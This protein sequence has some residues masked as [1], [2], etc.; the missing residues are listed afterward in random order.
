MRRLILILAISA[1]SLWA[2]TTIEAFGELPAATRDQ[3]GDTVGGIGSGLVFDAKNDQFFCISDRGPGDG[4]LPY[5]PRIAVLKIPQD[6]NTLRPEVLRTIILKDAEGK[7]MT[8]LIPD[9]PDASFP[10]MKDGRTCIDPEAIALE[11][12]GTFYVTDEYGPLLYQFSADGVML[13]R[14][15]LPAE[16]HPRTA[17]GKIDYTHKAELVSGRTVN[18]GPEG[19]CLVPDTNEAALIFQ[20]A[21]HQDGGR[22]AGQSK[23]LFIDRTTGKPTATYLYSHSPEAAGGTGKKLSVNDLAPL[24]QYRFL[25]LERDGMGRDGSANPEAAKYKSVWLIDIRG[26]TNLLDVG[27]SAKVVPVKKQLLFNLAELTD[28]ATLS[29]KWEG[30]AVLSA[31]ENGPLTLMMS[32]DNDFLNPNIFEAGESYPFPRAED[33]VPGQFFKIRTTLSAGSES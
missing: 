25:V 5:R 11:A 29:A 21:L 22:K 24:D 10:S 3:N 6:G 1:T 4:T 13:R 9:N 32:S 31:P 15:E 23:L 19:M 12:D 26:A 30:I 8:G 18:Q 2:E 17:E 33:A 28:P 16:F 14:I 27:S 20:S 7:A